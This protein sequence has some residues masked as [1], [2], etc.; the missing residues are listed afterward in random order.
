MKFFSKLVISI[1][2]I[3]FGFS[4]VEARGGEISKFA[5]IHSGVLEDYS[6]YA[7]KFTYMGLQLVMVPTNGGYGPGREFDIADFTPFRRKSCDYGNDILVLSVISLSNQEFKNFVGLIAGFPGLK[8]IED[9]VEPVSSLMIIRNFDEDAKC[10]EHLSNNEETRLLFDLLYASVDPSR[11]D[12][13]KSIK[14]CKMNM[15]GSK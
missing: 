14:S 10:W 9:V 11:E 13:L 5:E 2:L 3:A 8:S 1:L 12:V 6:T 7:Y 15:C 4:M